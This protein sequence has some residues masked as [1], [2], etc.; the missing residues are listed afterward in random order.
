MNREE[1]HFVS[2]SCG[3]H[4]CRC[5]NPAT[6][7]VG[8]EIPWDDPAS[9]T[10]AAKRGLLG[11]QRHNFTA[12]VCCTCFRNIMGDAVFCSDSD[13]SA[14]FELTGRKIEEAFAE[15]SEKVQHALNEA[16]DFYAEWATWDTPPLCERCET[17]LQDGNDGLCGGCRNES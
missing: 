3:G 8:E 16:R 11:Q 10:E 6:H 12:Y 5:G 9:T 7:K 2:R 14:Y 17:D 1:W 15:A 4:T 13:E